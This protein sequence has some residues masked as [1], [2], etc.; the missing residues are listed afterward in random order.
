MLGMLLPHPLLAF[1]LFF[2]NGLGEVACGLKWLAF[3]EAQ[4][5]R[6]TGPFVVFLFRAW[7]VSIIGFGTAS[8]AVAFQG[9]FDS[10]GTRAF[11]AGANVYHAGIAAL[12]V[13][14]LGRGV[15]RPIAAWRIGT[16]LHLTA[17]AFFIAL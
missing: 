7:A 1:L 11:S 17:L 13:N 8:L 2:L 14:G 5:E 15:L 10:D 9:S 4:I 6:A 16:A 12:Y 3:P